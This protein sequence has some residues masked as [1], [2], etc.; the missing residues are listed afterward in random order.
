MRINTSVQAR[1]AA[2]LILGCSHLSASN[3]VYCSEGSPGGFDPGQYTTGTD[4]DAASETVFNR[5]AQ[6][7]RGGTLAEPALATSWEVSE[8]GLN[9]LCAGYRAFFTHIDAPMK[10]MASLLRQGRYADEIMQETCP[11]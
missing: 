10:A 5:L 11:A 2:G 1:F 9:Y 4:F 7:E 6:F 8:D 3:L